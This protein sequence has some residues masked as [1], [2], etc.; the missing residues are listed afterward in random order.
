MWAF[1]LGD[2]EYSFDMDNNNVL[3]QFISGFVKTEEC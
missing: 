3:F 2:F 1:L